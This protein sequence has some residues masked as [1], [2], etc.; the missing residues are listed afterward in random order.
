[1]V[2]LPVMILKTKQIVMASVI[3][4]AVSI[5]AFKFLPVFGKAPSGERQERIS[6]SPNYKNGRFHNF[7][8][9]PSFTDGFSV[10]DIAIK[11]FS[12]NKKKLKP[13][14][15]LPSVKTNLSELPIDNDVLVWFGHS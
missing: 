1:M 10:K 12:V 3:S 4:A 13:T 5:S 11:Q 7:E 14:S 2:I 9:T 15:P 8:Y 6:Q